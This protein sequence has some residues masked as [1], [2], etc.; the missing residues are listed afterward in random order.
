MIAPGVLA[1]WA[2]SASLRGDGIALC[3]DDA[4]DASL[5]GTTG[6]TTAHVNGRDARLSHVT[7]HRTL[8]L[9]GVMSHFDDQCNS[10]QEV[11]ARQRG[12]WNATSLPTEP[13][14]FHPST[15]IYHIPCCTKL[16]IHPHPPGGCLMQWLTR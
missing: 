16:P 13:P 8:L 12:S 7:V 15:Y 11:S 2:M 9:A 1:G 6:L 3:D 4:R 10:T 5:A 14:A